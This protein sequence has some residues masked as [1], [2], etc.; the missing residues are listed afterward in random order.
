MAQHALIKGVGQHQPLN[1][2]ISAHWTWHNRRGIAHRIE[3]VPT[4][5]NLSDPISRFEDLPSGPLW[6]YI[7]IPEEAITGRCLQ[8]IG[9]IRLASSLGFEDFPGMDTVRRCF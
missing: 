2:L 9:D 1:C 4:E 7:N 3:R 8:V 6:S 5:A